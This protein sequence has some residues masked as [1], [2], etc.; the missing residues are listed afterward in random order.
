VGWVKDESCKRLV[1]V[2]AMGGS[3]ASPYVLIVTKRILIIGQLFDVSFS[4]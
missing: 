2:A 3:L 4:L 1:P